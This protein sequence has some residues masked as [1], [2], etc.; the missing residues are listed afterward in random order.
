MLIGNA[1]VTRANISGSADG[2]DTGS[3][4]VVQDSYIHDL[5]Y[6]AECHSQDDTLQT[7]SGNDTFRHNTLIAYA[8][9]FGDGP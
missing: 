5:A 2:I 3:T 7:P 6:N 1:T 8:G 4:V 9:K